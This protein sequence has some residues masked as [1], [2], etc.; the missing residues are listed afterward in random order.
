MAAYLAGDVKV[1]GVEPELCPTLHAALAAGQP[2]DVPVG[3]IAAD[4][5]GGAEDRRAYASPIAQ[6]Y[7]DSAVLVTDDGDRR[8]AEACSGTGCALRSSPAARRRLR[9]Y[10]P[11]PTGPAP[12]ER[13]GVLLC[14]A[15]T[16]A[17]NFG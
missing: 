10:L 9:R 14:G 4:S 13:V 6:K 17:V 3:G 2:V 16:G 5:L 15:N 1:V 8:R 12:G 7:I 11:V